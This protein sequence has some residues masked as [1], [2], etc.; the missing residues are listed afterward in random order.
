MTTERR[1]VFVSTARMVIDVSGARKILEE[2]RYERQRRLKEW[3]VEFLAEEMKV[4]R[5]KPLT[6]IELVEFDG[7]SYLV[8][9]QHRLSAVVKCG[10]SQEFVVIKRK[11]DSLSDV[12]DAY[13]YTD[14]GATRT[15]S[16]AART[17]YLGEEFGLIERQLNNVAGAGHF[18]HNGFQRPTERVP[19]DKRIDWVRAHG[20]AGS[21]YYDY[22][23]GGVRTLDRVP[24]LAVGL[25][26]L[27]QS[28]K[29]LGESVIKSFW[30]GIA[31]DDGLKKGD[32]RKV[33]LDHLRKTVI[34]G[35]R[36]GQGMEMTTAA[37]SSRCL[38]N[39]FNAHARRESIT[40]TRVYDYNAPITIVGSIYKG[41]R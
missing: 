41:N 16:D 17:L 21:V 7:K 40:F 28:S 24:S 1:E 11:V 27:E 25:I 9:G 29:V 35:T 32:P 39:C 8:D 13:R 5:F 20:K 6:P 3:H 38:A 33:A 10:I 14:I 34:A 12:A 2:C 19:Q 31:Q 22:V 30:Q 15:F 36:L 37:Y 18:I 26:T 23:A 4:G